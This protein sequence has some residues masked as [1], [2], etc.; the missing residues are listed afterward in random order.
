MFYQ[1]V[2]GL[3]NDL[4]GAQVVCSLYSCLWTAFKCSFGVQ[5]PAILKPEPE[6]K[7]PPKQL[8]ESSGEESSSDEEDEGE[9]PTEENVD[10]N[11][12]P[13]KELTKKVGQR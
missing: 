3:R 9:N 13:Q 12:E 8:G 1:S 4:G 5:V 10:G 6:K 2:T 11:G 7:L